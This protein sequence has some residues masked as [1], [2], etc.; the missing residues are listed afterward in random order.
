M[1][2]VQTADI[3]KMPHLLVGGSTGSGKSV[4]INSF[5]AS[6]LMRYRPEEVKLVL[7]DPKKVELSN[8]NGVPHLLWPVV[9]DPK[10]ANTALQRVVAMMEDRYE[11]F[12]ETGVKNIATYN[13]MVEKEI[14]FEQSLRITNWDRPSDTITA[15]SPEIHVNRERRLSARECAMLQTFPMDYEFVGSLNVIYRQIGNAVPVKLAEQIAKGIY[16]ILKNE[17]SD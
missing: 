2:K 13:E 11:L 7:V 3:S 17:E 12:S 8:Y 1:G 15:T 4:C 14:K 10:K 6:I 16:E 5:I 9:T